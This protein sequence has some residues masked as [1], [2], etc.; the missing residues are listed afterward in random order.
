MDPLAIKHSLIEAA[1]NARIRAL[2]QMQQIDRRYA[3]AM[4]NVALA[5]YL[6]GISQACYF[7]AG[8]DGA[9]TPHQILGVLSDVADGF[10]ISQ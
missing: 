3:A 1:Q 9:A 6:T 2:A 5:E 4:A 7:L 8:N 10:G